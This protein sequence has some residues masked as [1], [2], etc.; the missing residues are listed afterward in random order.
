MDK[1]GY[2]SITAI[3]YSPNCI[4]VFLNPESSV[5]ATLHRL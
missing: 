3:D 5:D 1:D 4:K 2:H